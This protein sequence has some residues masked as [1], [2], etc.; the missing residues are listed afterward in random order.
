M[1]ETKKKRIPRALK[2]EA[3]HNFPLFIF[4]R[5]LSLSLIRSKDACFHFRAVAVSVDKVSRFS[6]PQ[7]FLSS[8]AS[9]QHF[10]NSRQQ[11]KLKRMCK[12]FQVGAYNGRAFYVCE[13]S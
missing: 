5:R 2:E 12:N 4:V 1:E 10:S 6:S 13:F 7:N 3:A 8:P 9:F 11:S